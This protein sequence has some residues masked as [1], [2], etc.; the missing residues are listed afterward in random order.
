MPF[1]VAELTSHTSGCTGKDDELESIRVED[2]DKAISHLDSRLEDLYQKIHL[3]MANFL[4]KQAIGTCAIAESGMLK[5]A[6][7][8]TMS[9][10]P[11][12]L[13][14]YFNEIEYNRKTIS[15]RAGSLSSADASF[16][17]LLTGFV[18]I[19][20]QKTAILRNLPAKIRG[21]LISIKEA[22]LETNYRLEE[23]KLWKSR[24]YN[25]SVLSSGTAR[26]KIV[27]EFNTRLLQN[28]TER[29]L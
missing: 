3:Y 11:D 10:K 17:C 1:E 13:E 23:L 7:D 26:Q 20:K 9:V 24:C 21:L 27:V 22:D 15:S 19:A 5:P 18:Q 16:C 6:M 2:I 28:S 4:S 29:V 12:E 25:M 8:I 14:E